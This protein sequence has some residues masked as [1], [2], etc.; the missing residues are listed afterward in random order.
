MNR[1]RLDVEAW[2]DAML[3]VT[4]QLNLKVGGPSEN[5]EASDMCRRTLYGSVSRKVPAALLGQFDFPEATR[6]SEQRSITTTPLQQLF[7]MNSG[8]MQ[9]QSA[10]VVDSV[11]AH[12]AADDPQSIARELF[13]RILSRNP[14]EEEM[15]LSQ[16][17][18]ADTTELGD[19]ERWT[20]LA[21]TLLASNEFLFVD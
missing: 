14:S 17:L 9:A 20:M 21:Q 16:R 5:L 4:G 13:R 10:A 1:R 2:R 11:I 18:F 3:K 12:H 8:F 7:F 15:T 6:H 19:R